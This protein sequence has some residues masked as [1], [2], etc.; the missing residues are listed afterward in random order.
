MIYKNNKI[1][2]EM[3]EDRGEKMGVEIEYIRKFLGEK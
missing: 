2:K 3:E 1:A